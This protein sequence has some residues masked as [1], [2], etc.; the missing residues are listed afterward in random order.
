M[1][2]E[3]CDD[4][5]DNYGDG[6]SSDCFIEED[7]YCVGGSSTVQDTCIMCETMFE[8]SSDKTKCVIK[9]QD[10]AIGYTVLAL[11]IIFIFSSIVFNSIVI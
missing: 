7:Y 6:C 1:S 3:E 11:A 4:G 5:N 8:P 10:S 9:T 2:D